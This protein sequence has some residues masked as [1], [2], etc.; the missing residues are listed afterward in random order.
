MKI[1]WSSMCSPHF[2]LC[3][4]HT[5]SGDKTFHFGFKEL[6]VELG[7]WRKGWIC[8]DRILDPML[9][10]PQHKDERRC[11]LSYIDH[12]WRRNLLIAGKI[13]LDSQF[14]KANKLRRRP[15]QTWNIGNV[16]T[17]AT[18]EHQL[19]FYL[20]WDKIDPRSSTS[21]LQKWNLFFW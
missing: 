6:L 4:K 5:L 20:A 15:S 17:N 11:H 21:T 16:V 18:K 10:T 19:T 8:G 7:R 12:W 9:T 13:V 14:I 1:S 2:H 3:T